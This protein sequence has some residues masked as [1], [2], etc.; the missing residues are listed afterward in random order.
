MDGPSV[1]WKFYEAV[2]KDRAENELHQL[3]QYW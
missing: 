1:N 3:H 2:T